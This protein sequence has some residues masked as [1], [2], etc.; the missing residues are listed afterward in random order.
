M[1]KVDNLYRKYYNAYKSD[2]NTDDKLN[3]DKKK[4]YDYKQFELDDEISKESKL[5]GRLMLPKWVKVSEKRFNEI[6]STVTKAQNNGLKT[7]RRNH[8][9]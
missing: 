3:E 6:L 8:T 1:K 9:R 7:R 2:Y 5:P 4:T